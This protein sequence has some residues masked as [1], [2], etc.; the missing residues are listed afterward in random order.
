MK[1]THVQQQAAIMTPIT[2]VKLNFHKSNNSGSVS[3]IASAIMEI[4]KSP[5]TL[6]IINDMDTIIIKGF[7]FADAKLLDLQRWC[8]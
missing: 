4:N 6:N 1:D 8:V 7:T 2:E 3:P 5:I